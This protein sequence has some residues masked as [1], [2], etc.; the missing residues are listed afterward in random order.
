MDILKRIL[1]SLLAIIAFPVNVLANHV[2]TEELGDGVDP[3]GF[4][5]IEDELI[6][7]VVVHEALEVPDLEIKENYKP[8][9]L[10]LPAELAKINQLITALYHSKQPLSAQIKQ[11]IAHL[12][13]LHTQYHDLSKKLE[14]VRTALIVQNPSSIVDELMFSEVTTPILLVK[15]FKKNGKWY[16][17]PAASYVTDKVSLL[18]WL[19][20]NPRHPII[21]DILQSPEPYKGMES[22][23]IW[24][25][26]TVE[27]CFS[28]ELDEAAAQIRILFDELSSINLASLPNSQSFF[29]LAPAN[30]QY[31]E[32]S[33]SIKKDNYP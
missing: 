6:D 4:P 33:P 31:L 18:T 7:V 25:E 20:Q 19:K 23:Y 2:L 21:R 11:K 32:F 9:A 14:D 16:H 17:V 13:A 24:Y 22:K 27:H 1:V 12:S 28:Q 30:P 15:Q 8:Q 5:R 29:S 3:E 26:L 10:L